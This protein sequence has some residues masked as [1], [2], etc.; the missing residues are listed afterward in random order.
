MKI[1][2]IVIGMVAGLILPL[3]GANAQ[4]VFDPGLSPTGA[5]ADLQRGFAHTVENF[6]RSE[7]EHKGDD[8]EKGDD[9][10]DRCDDGDHSDKGK[11]HDCHRCDDGD[12]SDKGHRDE[13]CEKSKGRRHHGED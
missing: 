3:I 2:P 11:G 5:G 1:R 13:E 4:A 10:R 6:G 8:C 9:C 7:N 12:H